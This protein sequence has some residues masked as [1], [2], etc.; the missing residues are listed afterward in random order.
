[1]CSECIIPRFRVFVNLKRKRRLGFLPKP[2]YLFC[3]LS[4][5]Y[6]PNGSV[7]PFGAVRY[8]ECMLRLMNCALTHYF[9]KY[10]SIAFAA[11]LPAPMAEITVAAPVTASPPAYT[12]SLVVAPSSVTIIPP[13]RLT[14]S[15]SVVDLIRGL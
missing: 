6:E 5:F 9:R 14:S 8:A 1:M 12:P 3:K 13:Q 7:A 4:L 2:P 10:S 11:V 15:P